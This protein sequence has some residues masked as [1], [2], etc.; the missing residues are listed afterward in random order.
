MA[1][2]IHQTWLSIPTEI[3][4][5]VSMSEVNQIVV[6][7]KQL[8]KERNLTQYD[9]A[10]V[11]NLGVARVKQMFAKQDF[12]IGRLSTICS[13]LLDM[14]LADL[15][16]I[17]QD[18]QNYIQ[19][20]TEK[21][22][23]QLISDNRLLVVAV[24]VMNNWTPAEIVG[25][26]DISERE[27][28]RYLK[29]LEKLELIS[30]RSSGSIKLLIDRNFK[31]IQ[32][33]PLENFFRQHVQ[34]DFLDAGFDGTGEIRQFRTGMLTDKSADELIKKVEK[35]VAEFVDLNQIDSKQELQNRAGYSFLIALRPWLMPAFTELLRET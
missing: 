25:N 30:I 31:W 14:D 24:S 9:V 26:Y 33:G 10:A 19:H 16:Q 15:M 20:L 21:Q 29:T 5:E 13:E 4:N 34:S 8:L 1:S 3:H 27:C 35:I 17:T 2:A 7:L 28:Q 18:R 12:S 11:L 32:D 6:T 22:E 23:R